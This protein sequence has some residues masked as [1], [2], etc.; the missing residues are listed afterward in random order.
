MALLKIDI[1]FKQ[2]PRIFWIVLI[3]KGQS[4]NFSQKNLAQLTC[5]CVITPEA[6]P[7]N[8][9]AT[10][11]TP[12][13]TLSFT[14][15]ISG[16]AMPGPYWPYFW[17]IIVRYVQQIDLLLLYVYFTCILHVSIKQYCVASILILKTNKIIA[18]YFHRL[19]V[20]ISITYRTLIRQVG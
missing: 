7:D 15:S 18:I 9:P 13:F 1:I 3:G 14:S 2:G 10:F 11:D 16:A 20:Q 19:E 12:C 17:A 5:N 6:M 8:L 4:P